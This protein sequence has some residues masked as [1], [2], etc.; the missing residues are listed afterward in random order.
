MY[1][2]APSPVAIYLG[3]RRGG[4]KRSRR[5]QTDEQHHLQET[6]QRH[7]NEMAPPACAD[8]AMDASRLALITSRC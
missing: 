4:F 2:I 6:T 1:F 8:G 5:N 7:R 3:K